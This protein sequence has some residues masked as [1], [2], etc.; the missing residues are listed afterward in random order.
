MRPPL[1]KHTWP[2]GTCVIVGDPIITGINEKRL[3]KNRLVTVHDFRGATLA[4]INHH[5]IPILKKKPDVIILHV[6]TN[7]SVSRT[8]HE[9][10]DDMLQL[11]SAITKTTLPNCQVIFSQPTLRVDNGKAALTLHRLNEHFQN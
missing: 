6:V 1:R 7:G 4:D 8:S 10:V 9:I 11:K 5:T 2:A 3:S